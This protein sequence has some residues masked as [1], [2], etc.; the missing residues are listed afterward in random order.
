MIHDKCRLDQLFFTEL[1][2]EQVNDITL[3][4]TFFICNIVFISQFLS[5]CIIFYLIE[6]DSG[7]FLDRIIHGQTLKRLTEINLDSIIGN[8]CASANLFSKITEHGLCQF[9]HTFIVCVCLI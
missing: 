6:V 2:K 4:M 7:I 1:L 8:L 9:H 5:C 3:L